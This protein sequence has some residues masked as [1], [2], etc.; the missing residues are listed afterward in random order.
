MIGYVPVVASVV[1]DNVTL[2]A[3]FTVQDTGVGFDGPPHPGF[4]LTQV[5]ERL[6]TAYGPRAR[7][8][9]TSTRGQGTRIT[10]TLPLQS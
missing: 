9:C 2:V 7:L 3:Q 6:A 1:V 8:D 5:R 10:L 4:G